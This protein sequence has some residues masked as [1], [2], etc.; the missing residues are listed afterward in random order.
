MHRRTFLQFSLLAPAAA[1]VRPLWA[2][3]LCP[4]PPDDA[5]AK[6]VL[7]RRQQ[8]RNNQPFKFLDASFTVKVSGRDTGGRYVIFD[9]LRPAKV[10]PALHY[11]KDCDEWFC[12]E[13]GEF[14]FQAGPETM[15]L[16][17]GD[18]LLVPRGVAHTF[19]KTSEG[20]ARLLVMHQPAGTMEEYFRTASQL[21]DQSLEGRRALAAQHDIHIVGPALKPD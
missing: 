15:R 2:G 20:V 14:K 6:A 18:T 21:A 16:Q 5:P 13:E 11:H 19:I 12:V 10:G 4:T 8:D 7:V 3:A 1:S 9:T 17:A